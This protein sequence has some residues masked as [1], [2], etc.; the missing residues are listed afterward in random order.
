MK[1]YKK[2]SEKELIEKANF[3][4]KDVIDVCVKNN[5][6]HIA[7]SLSCIDILVSLYYKVMDIG[8]DPLSEKR[9]SQF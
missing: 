2:L 9:D 7:P 3:I 5:A 1:N 4:R 6:G 8:D